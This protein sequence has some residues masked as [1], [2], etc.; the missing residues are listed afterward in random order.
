MASARLSVE[1]PDFARAVK[2]ATALVDK[3]ERANWDFA[4]APELYARDSRAD[5][6][7]KELVFVHDGRTQTI[8]GRLV[9]G[10]VGETFNLMGPVQANAEFRLVET[11]VFDAAHKST[12]TRGL[13]DLPEFRAL[14]PAQPVHLFNY[15]YFFTLRDL[16][17]WHA[18]HE[19][20]AYPST[21]EH[22]ARNFP[23]GKVVQNSMYAPPKPSK[24]PSHPAI[25]AF[26]RLMVTFP[27]PKVEWMEQP[28]FGGLVKET[29]QAEYLLTSQPS[30]ASHPYLELVNESKMHWSGR[31]WYVRAFR[32]I[33][34][35]DAQVGPGRLP[36]GAA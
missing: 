17:F 22:M 4:Q 29:L 1:G 9:T 11:D 3:L 24:D 14:P 36:D 33:S 12:G 21:L 35:K 23:M 28:L 27:T 6:M 13:D 20:G 32:G 34:P 8:F 26:D 18:L 5:V 16:V 25:M 15:T 10:G 30:K 31:D 19:S 7:A 2:Q